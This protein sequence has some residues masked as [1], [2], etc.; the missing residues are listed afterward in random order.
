MDRLIPSA[1]NART[2]SDAQVAQLAA[3]IREWGLTTAVLVDPDGNIIAG[4]GRVLAARQIGIAE[5][6]VMVASGWS[7]AKKRAYLIADNKLA[8]NAGWNDD[9][10]SLE[11]SDLGEMG[12]D[13]GLTGFS[14]DE[15]I[16][17]GEPKNTGPETFPEVDENIETQHQCP[18]CGYAYSGGKGGQIE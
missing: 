16:A 15:I 6:P 1:R 10:L 14:I 17:L 4:H 13:V 5:M 11:I 3:S 18:R 7:D 12:F 8:M 9:L 2:H